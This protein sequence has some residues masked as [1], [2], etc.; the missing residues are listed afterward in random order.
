MKQSEMASMGGKARW[1]GVADR[2]AIMRA[3]AIQGWANL[4]PE[5]RRLRARKAAATRKARRLAKG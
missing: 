1:V 5:A 3:V 4:G 2:S